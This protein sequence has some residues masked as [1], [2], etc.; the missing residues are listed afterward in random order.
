MNRGLSAVGS[1]APT[2][3][4]CTDLWS[5]S[6][7]LF[8]MFVQNHPLLGKRESNTVA[9]GLL[10]DADVCRLIGQNPVFIFDPSDASNA[11]DAVAQG[12]ALAMWSI[13]PNFV[14]TLF[15]RAFTDGIRDPLNGRVGES[16]WRKAMARLRDSIVYCPDCGCE[17]FADVV[18]R[19]EPQQNSAV[20]WACGR[21][22][23][24]PARLKFRSGEVVM[25]N[26][27][28]ML[29]PHHVDANRPYDFSTPVAS[30]SKHPSRPDVWGLK[31]LTAQS[32][33]AAPPNGVATEVPQGRT[34]RIL[35]GMR[36]H[37]GGADGE[38]IA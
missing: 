30:V 32:W 2:P 5:L 12:T 3:G 14:R 4:T 23:R 33:T 29:Y 26:A 15:I 17:C 11:P 1:G 21:N 18:G 36:I 6:V 7:L 34:A 16:E 25:L 10:D 28:T 38:I 31:N 35:D 27:R 19:N 22:F 37:F 13:Y 9:R 20:C 8:Y 24:L